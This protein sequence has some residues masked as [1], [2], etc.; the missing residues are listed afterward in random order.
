MKKITLISITLII[1]IITFLFTISCNKE[2]TVTKGKVLLPKMKDTRKLVV[3]INAFGVKWRF[4]SGSISW[5]QTMNEPRVYWCEGWWGICENSSPIIAN[6]SDD[7]DD[8][9]EIAS[10]SAGTVII[11]MNDKLMALTQN[12][13]LAISHDVIIS[14]TVASAL[15]ISAG[16]TIPAGIYP[17]HVESN[18]KYIIVRE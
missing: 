8:V 14:S 3:K 13:E 11:V 18:G 12:G 6:P 7:P 17:V 4:Q 10:D 1:T 5:S 16:F 2:Q 15:Q 9:Y